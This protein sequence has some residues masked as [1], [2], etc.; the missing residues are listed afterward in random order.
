MWAVFGVVRFRRVRG[1]EAARRGWA[2][3]FLRART[4][5]VLLTTLQLR[6]DSL[7]GATPGAG[8]ARWGGSTLTRDSAGATVRAEAMDWCT[9]R[10]S[11]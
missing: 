8:R 9:G 6:G 11:S 10:D 2:R 3:T 4:P 5:K 7:L 1:G